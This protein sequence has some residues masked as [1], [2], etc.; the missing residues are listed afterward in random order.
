MKSF[1]Y[2]I[3]CGFF[4]GLSVFAP[5]ISGSVMAVMMGNYE[6]LLGILAEPLK[7][8][9]KNIVY[10]F[11][12]GIGALLSLVLFILLFS[13]LF[14]RYELESFLLFV[15]LIAGNLPTVW[16][17][18]SRNG[19]KRRYAFG[20]ALAFLT[21]LG[22]SLIRSRLLPGPSE[23][24][25]NLWYLGL[26]GAVT[27]I[28]AP[29][30][31]MSCS[32]VLIVLG[33]YDRLMLA[34]KALDIPVILTVGAC[35]TAAIIA[36]ARFVRFIFKRYR[37]FAYFMVFGFLCGSLVGV[38]IDLPQAGSGSSWLFGGFM[39]LLGLGISLLFVVFG[40][41]LGAE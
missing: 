24:A 11:P 13:Y 14:E 3:F 23:L 18:A 30:P 29:I 37:N 31:G 39:L 20:I 21:A 38:L 34:A 19:F 35:F 10:L 25:Q 15:G 9:K 26:S 6:R 12:M 40:K 4:L 22:T 5:G 33:V 41:R 32:L 17:E 27:G 2:R 28:A 36:F 8:L 16:K 7:D 1:F